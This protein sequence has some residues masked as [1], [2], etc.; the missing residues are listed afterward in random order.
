MT[1]H[2]YLRPFRIQLFGFDC[3]LQSFRELPHLDVSRRPVAVEDV[4]G[5][6]QL[7]GLRV[8][9]DGL[10]KVSALAGGV[11]LPDLLQKGGLGRVVAVAR[12]VVGLA[13][14]GVPH[15]VRWI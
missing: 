9:A 1:K 6:V 7:D 15:A 14:F 8:K 12:L 11:R 10:L 2:I 13:L 5:R 4:I 3:V